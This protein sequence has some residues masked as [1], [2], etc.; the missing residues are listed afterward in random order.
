[1]PKRETALGAALRKAG[2]RRSGEAA[3]VIDATDPLGNRITCDEDTW[4]VHVVSG[5]REMEGHEAAA[6]STI[7][8]PGFIT[9]DR[10][11]TTEMCYYRDAPLPFGGKMMKIVVSVKPGKSRGFLKSGWITTR[12]IPPSEQ[13]IWRAQGADT[14]P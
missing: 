4:G 14:T 12:D 13:E 5:H 10:Q 3:L 2:L 7:S 11:K 9:R 6:S 8:D 1:M